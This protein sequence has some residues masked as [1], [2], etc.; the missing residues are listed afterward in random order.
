MGIRSYGELGIGVIQVGFLFATNFT[1]VFNYLTRQVVVKLFYSLMSMTFSR[2]VRLLC[3]DGETNALDKMY[4]GT[5]TAHELAH[6]WFGNY[7]TAK[8]WDNVWVNEG[9]ASYFEHFAMHEVSI[10]FLWKD[11]QRKESSFFFLLLFRFLLL[12]H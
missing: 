8:W 2:E 11:F 10:R 5:I 1:V 9:F 12:V 6:K 7:I 4:I 3:E